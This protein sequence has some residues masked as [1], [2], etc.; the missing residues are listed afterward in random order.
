M[1]GS[2]SRRKSYTKYFNTIIKPSIVKATENVPFEAGASVDM[3]L[4]VIRSGE[5]G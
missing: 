2:V 5:G 3:N 4:V 1:E